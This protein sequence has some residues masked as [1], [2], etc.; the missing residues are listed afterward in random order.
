MS[1]F[2][3]F[4]NKADGVHVEATHQ[5]VLQ[6]LFR[7]STVVEHFF[8]KTISSPT[9]KMESHGKLFDLEI[10]DKNDPKIFIELKMWS[11]LGYTQFTDQKKKAKNY[12]ATLAYFLIGASGM[13]W[14]EVYENKI[15]E[16]YKGEMDDVHFFRIDD[17]F[18]KLESIKPLS[19]VAKELDCEKDEFI[20]FLNSY[21]KSLKGLKN[22]LNEDAKK[23]KYLKEN[24]SLHFISL[25]HC[26][27]KSLNPDFSSVLYRNRGAT[28]LELWKE[29]KDLKVNLEGIKGRLLFVL[30]NKN[31]M[32][33]FGVKD[34]SLQKIEPNKIESI[35]KTAQS[36]WSDEKGN[37]LRRMKKFPEYLCLL[38]TPH[39]YKSLQQ[40]KQEEVNIFINK[41]YDLFSN[42][43]SEFT[44]SK[45]CYSCVEKKL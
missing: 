11:T 7:S 22:W 15:R 3:L 4:L 27:K 1:S 30:K 45:K 14:D 38:S 44:I 43:H 25:F 29:D 19:K 41:W 33:F 10:K 37:T 40:G 28:N 34:F 35:R 13:E 32:I 21:K 36:F 12:N 26:L 39:P 20:S 8:G 2:F 18:E 16:K 5:R 6:F 42:F 23:E 31:L 24:I 17:I 9:T